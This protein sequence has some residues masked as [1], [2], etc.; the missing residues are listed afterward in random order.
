M[1]VIK[2]N[3]FL[4]LLFLI[5]LSAAKFSF[6]MRLFD[7]VKYMYYKIYASQFITKD[8]DK[9]PCVNRL[10]AKQDAH[11]PNFIT[12]DT[13][14]NYIISGKYAIK[15]K[16][17][18]IKIW[19]ITNSK[20]IK[21]FSKI[22]PITTLSTRPD[23]TILFYQD[24]LIEYSL[25]TNSGN[26]ED[27]EINAKQQNKFESPFYDKGK[28]ID[29]KGYSLSKKYCIT[30]HPET[31]NIILW[32]LSNKKTYTSTKEFKE[33]LNFPTSIQLSVGKWLEKLDE[34]S[35]IPMHMRPERTKGFKEVPDYPYANAT[36][37]SC[38]NFFVLHD[39]I[40][41]ESWET[42]GDTILLYKN[43]TS[44]T[45]KKIQ[46]GVFAFSKNI[47]VSKF[48][49]C[50]SKYHGNISIYNTENFKLYRTIP[51]HRAILPLRYTVEKNQISL[52]LF[53]LNSNYII[54]VHNNIIAIFDIQENKY[55][56]KFEAH[57][58]YI[59]IE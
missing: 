21:A 10:W 7:C 19:D 39:I 9:P 13:T 25:F 24:K 52:L 40:G 8:F 57:N 55:I 47:P 2:K 38:E 59:T 28:D 34:L 48:F 51:L 50:Y 30:N 18:K 12:F 31:Y 14:G 4:S 27:C 46:G 44:N 26:W 43:H 29:P 53:H 42:D 36:F 54:F 56:T 35:S 58:T 41:L 1:T 20:Y 22:A 16:K 32:E 17:G 15:P 45:I 6:G 3:Y 33:I 11:T 49:A 37:S 5:L 23:G